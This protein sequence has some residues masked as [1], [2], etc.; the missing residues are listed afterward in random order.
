MR[1][2][3]LKLYLSEFSKRK[4][5]TSLIT[6]AIAWATLSLLLMMAFGRGMSTQSRIGLKGLGDN[7]VMITNGRTSKDYQGLP[8]GRSVRIHA[9]DCDLIQSQ[10]PEVDIICPES[11]VGVTVRYKDFQTSRT[12]RGVRAPYST[13]RT[14]IPQAGGRFINPDDDKFARRVA[15][16]GWNLADDIFKNGEERIGKKIFINRVP[17]EV[18]GIMKKKMQSGNYQGLDYDQLYIP[19]ATLALVH[20]QRYIDRIHIQPVSREFSKHVED[21]AKEILGKKYR[22]DPEDEYA[23]G[24][25]NTIENGKIMNN[26]FLGI[27]IF[28]GLIGSLTLF[29]AA[30][31]V[32]NLMYAVVKERTREI[33][34]KMALG[35]KRRHIVLQF[36][37]EA[38]FIFIKGVFWGGLIAYNLVSLVRTVPISYGMT[39]SIQAYLLRPEFSADLLIIFCSIMGILVFISGIFPALRASKMNPVDALRY[40]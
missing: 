2:Q 14:I 25:W 37:M 4:K 38:F 11:Y 3:L 35:A 31:G 10:V 23:L 36:L 5:K 15:F 40:E 26:V 6:F 39:S 24:F 20:S 22:F 33:G 19:I 17:F 30:V 13:L 1:T 32:T 12:I 29:I 7:L 28:L 27:E 21:R 34:V 16:L 18:I 8:K 9:A